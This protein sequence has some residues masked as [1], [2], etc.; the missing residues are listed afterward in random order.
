MW[1]QVQDCTN[2]TNTTTTNTPLNCPKDPET[3]NPVTFAGLNSHA[4]FPAAS[5]LIVYEMIS[6]NVSES[7]QVQNLGG[8]YIGDRAK[9]DPSRKWVPRQELLQYIPPLDTVG[10]DSEWQ[11]AIYAGNWGSPLL[12]PAVTLECLSDDQMT[13][14]PCEDSETTQYV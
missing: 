3:G 6:G 5:D 9:A 10:N 13:K 4:N 14:A 8:L 2:T 12:L 1:T 7:F 11:W